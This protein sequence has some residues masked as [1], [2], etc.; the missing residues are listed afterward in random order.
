MDR[1]E[2]AASKMSNSGSSL[3]WHDGMVDLY[4]LMLRISVQEAKIMTV[5]ISKKVCFDRLLMLHFR[6]KF[7]IFI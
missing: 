7:E 6:K 2:D 4:P 1:H 3:I 5:K